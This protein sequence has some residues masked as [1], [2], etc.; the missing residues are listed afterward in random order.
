M[1][2]KSLADVIPGVIERHATMLSLLDDHRHECGHKLPPSLAADCQ[3]D[4]VSMAIFLDGYL[5]VGEHIW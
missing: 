3:R 4:T 1:S 5:G 2:T